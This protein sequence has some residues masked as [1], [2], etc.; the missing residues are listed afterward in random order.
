MRPTETKAFEQSLRLLSSRLREMGRT[1]LDESDWSRIYARAAGAPPQ[2]PSNL[3]LND[4]LHDGVGIEWK[5]LKRA[6]P[7]DML[8]KRISTCA[9]RVVTV[10]GDWAADYAKDS[11]LE[12]WG[13]LVEDFRARAGDI[14]WG[15]VL[16]N[17]TF[18]DYLYFEKPIDTPDPALYTGQWD[19][20]QTRGKATLSLGIYNGAGEKEF[21]ITLP[22][23]GSKIYT[24]MSVPQ[25]AQLISFDWFYKSVWIPERAGTHA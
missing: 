19:V 16:Y 21:A 8:G 23:H 5:F 18:K 22:K 13:G 9:T 2:K 10:N 25:N 14:K 15:I 1:T 11:V 20:T 4:Y 12:Q 7:G 6:K 17:G 24:Y 3:T